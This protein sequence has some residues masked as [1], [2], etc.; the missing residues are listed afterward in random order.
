MTRAVATGLGFCLAVGL[1]AG[2]LR[3]QTPAPATPDVTGR[4]SGKVTSIAGGQAKEEG[5]YAVLEQKGTAIGG[6]V[7]PRA[8]RQQ[9]INAGTIETAKGV[10]TVK[11]DSGRAGHVLRFELTLAAGKLTGTVK[12]EFYPDNKITVDLQREK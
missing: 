3:A 11:F 7:G 2:L 10:T 8:D 1:T 6:T 4:W 9:A 5:V 12:D